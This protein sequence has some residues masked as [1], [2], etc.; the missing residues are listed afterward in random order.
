MSRVTELEIQV[1]E[2]AR[3]YYL[4]QAVMPDSAFDKLL[5]EL[6]SLSPNSEVLQTVGWGGG[7]VNLRFKSNHF[8]NQTIGSLEK[9][10]HGESFG[11]R[12]VCT[13]KLD[14]CSVV[15]TYKN[16]Q[17]IAAITRGDGKVGQNV[18]SKMVHLIPASIP[19]QGLISIRGEVLITNDRFAELEARGVPNPR[20]YAAGVLNRD[21]L[22]DP[23]IKFLSFIA[24][25]IVYLEDTSLVNDKVTK[26]RVLK[27]LAKQGFKTPDFK[28]LS[29]E[30][31]KST[32]D[33]LL[34]IY[35]QYK[36]Q[37]PIDGL[38]ITNDT[39]K[40]DNTSEFLSPIEDSIAMK[41][42][43]ET[44]TTTVTGIEWKTGNSGR[45]NPVVNFQPVF[46]EG[47]TISAASGYN[48]KFISDFG[49]D[50]GTEITIRKANGIIP[51]ILDTNCKGKS[52]SLIP[53][54][55]P[56]CGETLESDDVFLTCPNP[57]C[58]S[59]LTASIYRFLNIC[60]IPFGLSNATIDKL[61]SIPNFSTLENF[62]KSMK[63]TDKT[64]SLIQ[65]EFGSGHFGNLLL[66]LIQNVDKKLH[67]G[68][69]NWEFWYIFNLTN[70]GE[71]N[72]KKIQE[73][74]EQVFQSK[75]LD[76]SIPYNAKDAVL[77]NLD[78]LQSVYQLLISFAPLLKEAHAI[79]G[80]VYN[81]CYTG[82]TDQFKTRKVFFD[83]YK[84]LVKEVPIA[85][86]D[87]LVCNEPSSS[88]KY[89]YATAHGIKIITEKE[90]VVILTSIGG[91]K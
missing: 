39:V 57:L 81:M 13:P 50:A 2:A 47:S 44:A 37:F 4:G 9:I 90:A 3:Y 82:K 71:N 16:G 46:L 21:L 69:E 79:S 56:T 20:N 1:A 60:E 8:G 77:A 78:Y 17:P 61:L 62:I 7:S 63:D 25:S 31:Q 34:E 74:P 11:S 76:S 26:V 52:S 75:T 33:K 70:L 66:S 59:K 42:P 55:C 35:N 51:E 12:N 80:K 41:F 91:T 53:T 29:F 65:S 68:F 49:I 24:Y 43:G 6:K 72:A 5:E 30:N 10:Q 45:V 85:K 84:G 86:A 15:V 73:T 36:V 23:D 48:K 87:F 89:K 64:I 40:I 67:A 27:A 22:N 32:N 54:K 83:H 28:L 38:V 18:L 14:G 88:S 58:P 19:Y